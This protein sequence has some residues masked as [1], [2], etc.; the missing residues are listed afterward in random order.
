MLTEWNEFEDI[1]KS[2]GGAYTPEQF[3][4]FL[5]MH[6]SEVDNNYLIA[7]HENYHYWQ[8]VFTPY[9]H[10]KW[11][12]DRSVSAEVVK[13]WLAA[14]NEPTDK[15]IIPAAGMVNSNNIKQR[16]AAAE[17]FVQD[18]VR[19][20][21]Y[22]SERVVTDH[23]LEKMLPISMD[24]LSP[25]IEL[26]G[27]EYKLNGIDILESYAK[28]QEAAL[29]FWVEKRP[30]DEVIDPSK[31]SPTYYSALWYF[32]DKVGSN[33]II[34]FPV[35]CE[36]ALAVKHLGIIDKEGAWKDQYPAWRFIRIVDVISKYKQGDYLKVGNLKRKFRT[37]VD[38]TLEKCGYAGWD[39]CWDY[40]KQYAEQ[41]NMNISNDMLRAIEFKRKYP[42]ALSFPLLDPDVYCLMK[43]FHPYYY[44]MADSSR[45]AVN[46]KLLGQEVVFE[47]HFQA[48]SH[49]IC[50]HMSQRCMDCWKVQCGF[51]YY[52]I[53]G[54]KYLL[55]G[56]CD[57]HVDG[58]SD[59]PKIVL[60][61]NHDI[62]EGCMF[63]AFLNV[64]GRSV[65]ELEVTDISKRVYPDMFKK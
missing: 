43:D 48:L 46:S 41:T 5:N 27:T 57:G 29:A 10:M 2:I 63:E 28:F 13:I 60:N 50:G 17:I 47:N 23:T 1:Y 49:Q 6:S 26:N 36:L 45:Y 54:C 62:V 3:G 37:Y 55:D 51:S 15:K 61:E 19:K 8:T 33:R 31:L 40:V 42:W 44:V 4:V 59:L 14:T 9:G 20:V 11:S 39:E 53:K 22:A 30:F 32:I 34:E 16:A 52:G 24:E 12:C 64:I 56:I 35:V 25:T 7:F 21:A 18:L 38:M 65:K 58:E